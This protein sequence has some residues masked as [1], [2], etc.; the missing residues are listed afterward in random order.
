MIIRGDSDA[1]YLVASKAQSR[2]TGYIFM[3]NKGGNNQ[4]INGPIMVIAR[5]LKMVVASV[6]EASMALLYHAAREVV[7]LQ[8]TTEELRHKQ[9][10]TPLRRDNST[11]SGIIN[12]MIEQK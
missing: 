4:I 6:A 9:L 2:N 5:I 8:I 7:P 3:R 10:P 11:A 12:G 1:T